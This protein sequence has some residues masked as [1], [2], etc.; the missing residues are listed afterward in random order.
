MVSAGPRPTCTA[1]S[2]QTSLE[3]AAEAFRHEPI[4][5]WVQTAGTLE[6]VHLLGFGWVNNILGWYFEVSIFS[7]TRS[8]FGCL[9]LP[10]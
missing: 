7:K 1:A 4:Y 3:T 5:H 9:G 2:T 10:V 8:L 6:F